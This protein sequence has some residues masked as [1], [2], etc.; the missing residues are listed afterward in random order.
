LSLPEAVEGGHMG[1]ADFRVRNKVFASAPEAARFVVK[2]TREQQDMLASAEP[3]IFAPVKGGWGS[4]GWTY[5]TLATADPVTMKSALT[6][7]WRN[8]APKRLAK[9]VGG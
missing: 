3:A 4:R 2:L 9:A 5:V 1:H 7:A 6:M 8:V